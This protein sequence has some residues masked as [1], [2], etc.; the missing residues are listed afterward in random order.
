MKF[1]NNR[2]YN[3]ILLLWSKIILRVGRSRNSRWFFLAT[4]QLA[5]L[6]LS[7]DSFSTTLP[8]MNKFPSIQYLSAYGW[9]WFHF[10]NRFCQQQTNQAL[11]LGHRGA[12]KI[13]IFDSQLYQRLLGGNHYLRYHKLIILSIRLAEKTFA[14]LQK[15]VED[16]REER[17]NDVLIFL[18]GNKIDIEE[19]RYCL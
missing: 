7:I 4:K 2:F 12:G 8:A 11:T 6:P 3:Y 14:S 15:W 19:R 18:V 10:K 17:G 5:R 13:Q 9:N 16:V 1:E